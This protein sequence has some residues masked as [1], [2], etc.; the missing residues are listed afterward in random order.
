MTIRLRAEDEPGTTRGEYWEHAVGTTLVPYQ[1]RGRGETLRSEIR[2]AQVGAVT[3]LDFQM[4]AVRAL[5]TPDLVKKLDPRLVK[6]DFGLRG[7]GRFEQYGR[8][9]VL[10]PGE[11][12]LVDLS[13]PH[14]VAVDEALQAGIAVFPRALLPVRERDLRELAA[15]RFSAG[16]P[17]ASLVS[18]MGRELI[19]RL[20]AGEG[21][22]DAR[23][24]AAFID[25]VTLA[26]A[27][28]LDHADAVA[29]ETRQQA[30][31]ISI[32]AFIDEHLADPGLSPAAIAAA[33]HISVRTLHKL[34]EAEEQTVTASI[35]QR[36]LERC[37]QD[38]LDP[39]RPDRPVA[40]VGARWG[41]PDATAFNRAFRSA[42]GL[43][44][45]EYRALHL[46]PGQRAGR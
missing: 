40:A 34:Y 10:A 41:M 31:L 36:R 24:S 14:D 23:M 8:Q 20:D 44:P 29:T 11:F 45:G 38:L 1:L 19:G 16:D 25:L 6:V 17:F 12:Q 42:Y 4:P 22:R 18:A 15:V 33:H 9:N 13:G 30:T 21:P 32:H 46:V 3:V 28:R 43:P 37:R 26:A 39:A 7:L 27:T 5:R 2:K 35:R